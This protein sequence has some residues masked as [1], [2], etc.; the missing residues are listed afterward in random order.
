MSLIKRNGFHVTSFPALFDD[1][2]TRELFNW[3]N[4]NYASTSTS[5]PPVNVR[6][7]AEAFEIEMAAPGMDKQ[8]FKLEL[9][10][11]LLVISSSKETKE[12]QNDK[13][14]RRRE[15]CYQSFTRRL[16]LP[17]N[18]VDEQNISAQYEN[19]LLLVTV[20]KREEAKI[21]GPKMIAVN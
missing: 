20:P 17:E 18:V 9:D 8:D 6:E 15:F 11:N 13:N 3:G 19:G 10:G 12:E 14:Y 21:K 16:Q 4:N 2:F 1:L 5:I 7:T